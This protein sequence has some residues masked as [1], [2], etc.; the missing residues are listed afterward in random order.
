[1][2]FDKAQLLLTSMR[3]AEVHA[4]HLR[5][6]ALGNPYGPYVNNV[7]YHLA[8]SLCFYTLDASWRQILVAELTT[9]NSYQIQGYI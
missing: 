5:A 7:P 6:K 1:M 3:R 8:M 9:D 4:A 2:R